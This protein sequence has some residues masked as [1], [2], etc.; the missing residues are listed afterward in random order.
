M[1]TAIA[2]NS[3]LTVNHLKVVGEGFMRNCSNFAQSLTFDQ[4]TSI[5]GY[6]MNNCHNFTG[7]LVCN[8]P[9][10]ADGLT[11][12]DFTLV[13]SNSSDAMFATGVTLTGPYATV[14]KN[15]FYDLNNPSIH[16]FRKLIVSQ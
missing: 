1:A 10:S 6:F 4:V 2:F 13:T 5:G 7:P 9:S 12:S 16:R 8:S 11:Y 14:W 3:S 15:K